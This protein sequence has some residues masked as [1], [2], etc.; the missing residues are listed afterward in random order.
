MN[1]LLDRSNSLEKRN[2]W[3]ESHSLNE[4]YS[5]DKSDSFDKIHYFDKEG[6][7]ELPTQFTF[8]FHYT[9]HPLVV[10]AAS[11]VCTYLKTKHE[12]QEELSH[13]KMLGVLLIQTPDNIPAYLAAFS[14]N[15]AGSNLHDFFVPPVF[16]LLQPG[17]FFKVE[18]KNISD[19][20]LRV[21]TIT[22]SD[23]Y[24]ELKQAVARQRTS[25]DQQLK[26]ARK[27]LKEE[28]TKRDK[29]RESINS[30][31]LVLEQNTEDTSSDASYDA[32]YDAP[33]DAPN[34]ASNEDIIVSAQENA[35]A[36]Q[37]IETYQQRLSELIKESQFQKAEFKR[38]ERKLKEELA[39][40][41]AH[42]QT[43]QEEIVHLKQE[44]KTRSAALQI[45][46]FEHFQMLNARGEVKDLCQIFQEARQ[47]VPPAGA[48]EC[49]LPKLL[50]YAY[51]HHLQPLAFG[52]F[53]WGNSPK[54]EIRH[55]GQFYPSCKGK[56]EPILQHM[57]VGLGVEENPLAKH[58]FDDYTLKVLYE[59]QWIVAIE[60][61]AGMLS[62]PGKEAI[63]S[64]SQLLHQQYPEA[65]GPLLVHR[66]DMATSG[67]LL[68]AKDKDTH[69]QLQA[70][71]EARQVR[72]IYTA[73]LDGIPRKQAGSISL[74]LCLNPL[75][76]P[77]QMVSYEHGK[78]A[79]THYKV[80]ATKGNAS[81]VQF[82]LE[83]G[84]THQIRMH[85]AHP[86]GLN[87]PIKG[88][89]LY[90]KSSDRLYLH[91]TEVSLVHPITHQPLVLRSEVPFG[92]E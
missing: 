4:N 88:D 60:K 81:L 74:P 27:S 71:F 19:I 5:L 40:T 44:R 91:A 70:L 24:Q 3:D 18:E 20:N 46:L 63:E 92:I 26:E 67:L 62:T 59:D 34:N 11:E 54:E 90:G 25:V 32:S 86:S 31:L 89:N 82:D 49:A 65:T 17:D 55:H 72:K 50:Q 37:T 57:L 69:A 29:E 68:A 73:V 64:V 28:K 10:R 56:C 61:P 76:R 53:W 8:P 87:C 21:S 2:T 30:K 22:S 51:L 79:I 41:E 35:T 23:K 80:L 7:F 43:L 58:L 85:A 75:D 47:S 83:T 12:W 16:D 33:K 66:L 84:R 45:K 13:G 42:F 52:E 39:T 1:N 48:G 6:S 36:Q 77:R 38:L 15:L 9:P 14:G 78:E